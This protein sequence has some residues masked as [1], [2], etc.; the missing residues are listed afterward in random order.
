MAQ[1]AQGT[2]DDLR[3]YIDKLPSVI[4]LRNRLEQHRSEGKLL[5]R[6]LK[7]ASEADAASPTSRKVVAHV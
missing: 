2:A 3:Q 5:K 1:N 7:L 4:T 6:L